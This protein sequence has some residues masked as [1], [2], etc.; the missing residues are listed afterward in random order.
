MKKYF[1]NQFIFTLS[2]LIQIVEHNTSLG[3]YYPLEHKYSK[4]EIT[5]HNW[6]NGF[7]GKTSTKFKRVSDNKIIRLN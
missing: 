6:N 4:D 1:K 7:K 2:E 3:F 5:I